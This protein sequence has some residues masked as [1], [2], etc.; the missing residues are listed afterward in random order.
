MR[1]K[2]PLSIL[3]FL[4]LPS[5]LVVAQVDKS[6]IKRQAEEAANALLMKDYT[7]LLKYTYPKV[8]ELLG[9]GEKMIELVKKGRAELE[10]QG[11]TI[12]SARIGD[13]SNTVRAGDE[14]HCLVPQT[15]TMKVPK[16][17]V[18]SASYLIGISGD[19]GKNWY[20][21]DTV[22]ITM[23]N[24]KNILPNYNAALVIPAKIPPVFIED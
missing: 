1:L 22:Q 18:R 14:I 2:K 9:G 4:L 24:V 10:S 20:F 5:I 7:I 6:T 21:I 19:D 13:P 3:L 16:G 17:K 12:D 8:V 23:E 15:V 11:I